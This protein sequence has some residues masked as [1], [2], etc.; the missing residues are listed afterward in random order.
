MDEKIWYYEVQI[1]LF[2]Y[3]GNNCLAVVDGKPV[4]LISKNDMVDLIE[5]V[6][7]IVLN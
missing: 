6:N 5:P 4:F 3:G 7:A 2:R 1:K